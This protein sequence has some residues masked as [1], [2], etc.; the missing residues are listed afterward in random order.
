MATDIT[1]SGNWMFS[2]RIGWA[3]SA[4]VSPVVVTFS[5]TAAA[6]SPG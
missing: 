3:S 2:S 6:M 4:S 1:G 5:P